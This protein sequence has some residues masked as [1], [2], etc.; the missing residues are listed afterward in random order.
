MEL[1]KN[2]MDV[3]KKRPSLLLPN[4][5]LQIIVMIFSVGI[6]AAIFIPLL[7]GNTDVEANVN[8]LESFD[9]L[10]VLMLILSVLTL[11]GIL[12][13]VWVSAGTMAL[14]KRMD[15]QPEEEIPWTDWMKEGK[16]HF[17][18][19]L[20]ASTPP[21]L[22]LLAA[23]LLFLVTTYSANIPLIFI[24][25]AAYV[26]IA[27]HSSILLYMTLAV[28]IYHPDETVG[29]VIKRTWKLPFSFQFGTIGGLFL[30]VILASFVL[31]FFGG[32]FP[33]VMMGV[34]IILGFLLPPFLYVY[35]YLAYKGTQT[36]KTE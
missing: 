27:W 34:Q 11:I 21:G 6:A 25:L 10:L 3:L 8:P 5:I 23:T 31:G 35:A 28:A 32:W 4:V 18:R 30:L 1:C 26:L 33:P 9:T 20:G 7:F 24:G 16:R 12:I 36:E 15:E 13:Q 14:A 22:Y 29:M 2:T 19:V 17:W